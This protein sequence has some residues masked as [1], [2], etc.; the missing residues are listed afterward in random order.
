MAYRITVRDCTCPAFHSEFSR[1]KRMLTQICESNNWK[2]HTYTMGH[3]F[4]TA[5][6]QNSYG[7]FVYVSFS[8]WDFVSNTKWYSDSVMVRTAKSYRDFLGGNNNFTT[9]KGL[10]CLIESLF[11]GQKVK[12]CKKVLI[13]KFK[14]K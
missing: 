14:R 7:N 2:L 13:R 6:I 10:E 3:Y 11:K 12:T 4:I 9:E 1:I 8:D 5:F